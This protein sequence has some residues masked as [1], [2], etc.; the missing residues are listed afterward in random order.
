MGLFGRAWARFVVPVQDSLLVAALTAACA[1]PVSAARALHAYCLCTACLCT[2]C[3]LQVAP[4]LALPRMLRLDLYLL[5]GA[6]ETY[7]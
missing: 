2:A 1:L 6:S 4:L 3:V 5:R 7:R